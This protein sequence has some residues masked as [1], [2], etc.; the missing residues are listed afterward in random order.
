MHT[1]IFSPI[2]FLCIVLVQ[3]LLQRFPDPSPAVSQALHHHP[4][5][6]RLMMMVMVTMAA[7]KDNDKHWP[8]LL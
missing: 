5:G 4:R 7:T 8:K 2:S 1:A 6:M 3:T